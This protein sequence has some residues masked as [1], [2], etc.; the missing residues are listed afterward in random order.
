MKFLWYLHFQRFDRNEIFLI[1]V[2]QFRG[3]IFQNVQ[4]IGY[5]SSRDNSKVGFIAQTFFDISKR[6]VDAKISSLD[7]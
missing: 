7:G 6:I 1:K 4:Q 5:T 3:K 2:F